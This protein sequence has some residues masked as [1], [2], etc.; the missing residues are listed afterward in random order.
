MENKDTEIITNSRPTHIEN[1]KGL[2]DA[3]IIE[4]V[5]GIK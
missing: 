2:S 5:H 4:I 3:V 1:S